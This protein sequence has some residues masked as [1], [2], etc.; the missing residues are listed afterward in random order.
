[1]RLFEF[2][3]RFKIWLEMFQRDFHKRLLKTK[4][5]IESINIQIQGCFII[6]FRY[7]IA[8]IVKKNEIQVL[9]EL[10][11]HDKWI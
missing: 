1:M 3:E 11:F 8:Y 9:P 10:F 7:I 4:T 5:A 6:C 2:P